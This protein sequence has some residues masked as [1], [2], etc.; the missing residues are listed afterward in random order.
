MTPQAT[1]S[2]Q[3]VP[4]FSLRLLQRPCTVLL[5]PDSNRL[6]AATNLVTAAAFMQP[7]SRTASYYHSAPQCTGPTR[8]DKRDYY[9]VLGVPRDADKAEVKKGY[10]KVRTE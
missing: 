5:R 10:Y 4:A 6:L 2:A 8:A 1:L 3:A 7:V 9:D